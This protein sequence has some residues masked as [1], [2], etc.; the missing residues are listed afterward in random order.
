VNLQTIGKK[1]VRADGSGE[2]RLFAELRI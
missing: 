1:L 2:V